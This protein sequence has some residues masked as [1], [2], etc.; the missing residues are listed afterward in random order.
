LSS[1]LPRAVSIAISPS[2]LPLASQL[3]LAL[4]ILQLP[5]A[6]AILQLPLALAILQL[7]LALAS[8]S[9]IKMKIG[10]SRIL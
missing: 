3:A 8:G 6:L 10:F 1:Q 5:L 7:P 4:A 9:L 2:Q